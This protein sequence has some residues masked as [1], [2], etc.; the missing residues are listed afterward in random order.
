MTFFVPCAILLVLV[1]RANTLEAAGE[2]LSFYFF[3]NLE[4]LARPEVRYAKHQRRVITIVVVVTAV[5]AVAL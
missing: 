5:L 1:I 2:G 4:V 3:P